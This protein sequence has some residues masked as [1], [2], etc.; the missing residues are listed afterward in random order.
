MNDLEQMNFGVAIEVL[1][2]DRKISRKGW[3]GEGMYLWLKPETVVKS[4]WCKD[5]IIDIIE[6]KQL[7]LF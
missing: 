7:D 3:N 6:N 1:K 4:E 2:L 5:P